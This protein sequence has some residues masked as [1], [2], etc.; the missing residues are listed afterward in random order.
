MFDRAMPLTPLPY[1]HAVNLFHFLVS[2]LYPIIILYL[3]SFKMLFLPACRAGIQSNNSPQNFYYYLP[4]SGYFL[5]KGKTLKS[6]PSAMVTYSFQ[7]Q[8]FQ[9]F[10]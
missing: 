3:E 1:M 9:I 4:L 5:C 2:V 10:W 7:I 6:H 8:M